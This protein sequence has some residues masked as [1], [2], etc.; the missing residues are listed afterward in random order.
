MMTKDKEWLEMWEKRALIADDY[1]CVGRDPVQDARVICEDIKQKFFLDKSDL[2]LDLGCGGGVFANILSSEVKSIIGVDTSFNM[3]KR[4]N[5]NK[6]KKENVKFIQGETNILPFKDKS[7]SKVICYSSTFNY[8]I[9]DYYEAEEYLKELK[10]ISKAGA[11]VLIGELHDISQK[12]RI[13]PSKRHRILNLFRK[14]GFKGLLPKIFKGLRLFGQ[15]DNI[16][17]QKKQ[18][19]DAIAE[20][21]GEDVYYKKKWINESLW[22]DRRKMLKILRRLKLDGEIKERGEHLPYHERE[23]DI[24]FRVKE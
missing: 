13:A 11:L 10:R 24:L 16:K 21:F 8:S 12:W 5:S 22:Y 15:G 17:D 19:E 3:V 14:K 6:D 2:V 9:K 1:L 23:F 4:A 18:K 7:F 20:K